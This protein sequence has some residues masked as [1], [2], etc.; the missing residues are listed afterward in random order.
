MAYLQ[1]FLQ[2]LTTTLIL[3]DS[4][5]K[6][7]DNRSPAISGVFSEFLPPAYRSVSELSQNN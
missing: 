7:V 6:E 4:N 1:L 2:F 3:T 5:Q